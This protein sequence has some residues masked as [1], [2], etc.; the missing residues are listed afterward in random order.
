MTAFNQLKHALI[1]APVLAMSN[2]DANFVLRPNASNTEVSIM[3][4]QYNRSVAFMSKELNSS[5][6]NYHTTDH[7]FLVIVLAL[8]KMA[9]LS[10]WQK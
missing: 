3:L 8:Q 2:F 7:N 9:S 5:Q 1:Y 6:F 4:M 10:A